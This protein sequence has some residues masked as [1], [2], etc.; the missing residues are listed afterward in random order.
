MKVP[1]ISVIVP[2]YNVERYLC[3]CLDSI[4]TQ[5]ITEWEC[6]LVDD[7]STDKSGSICDEYAKKDG[8]FIVMHKENGGVSSARNLGIKGAHGEWIS[9]VDA[10]DE[11]YEESLSTLYSFVSDSVDIV[12]AGYV[13]IN[14]KKEITYQIGERKTY[15]KNRED[16]ILEVYKPTYYSYIG[17]PWGKLYR[18]DVIN[19]NALSYDETIS[20]SEDR[21]FLL[22]F[23][24]C[25]KGIAVITTT[26][27]YYYYQ[28]ADSV[29]GIIRTLFNPKVYSEI[30][31]MGKAYRMLKKQNYPKRIVQRSRFEIIV[32]GFSVFKLLNVT[33]KNDFRRKLYTFRLMMNESGSLYVLSYFFKNGIKK[34]I[35]ICVK[36]LQ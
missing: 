36:K 30:K 16:A 18:K 13:K 4:L 19:K 15:L 21:L 9:F 10:D 33:G 32:S 25:M 22:T 5:T 11:L 14:D 31:A 23:M 7:G 1:Q 3:K 12:V 2:V 34:I 29:M 26:P 28:R 35:N 24:S 17:Y 27:V 6:I 8:R 20:V